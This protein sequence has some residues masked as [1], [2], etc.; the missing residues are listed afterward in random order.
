METSREPSEH[1]K[2]DRS[3]K[4]EKDQDNLI[5]RTTSADEIQLA[6]VIESDSD[7]TPKRGMKHLKSTKEI[8][9]S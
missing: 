8:N 1:S 3:A 7:D 9:S 5:V 2:S 6:P 4:S